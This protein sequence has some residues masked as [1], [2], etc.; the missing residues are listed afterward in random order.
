VPDLAAEACFGDQFEDGLAVLGHYFQP[1]QAVH[2]GEV[3]ATEA[4]PRQK[5]IDA[6]TQRLVGERVHRLGQGL[7]APGGGLGAEG[8][9]RRVKVVQVQDY[10]TLAALVR[11]KKAPGLTLFG[12]ASGLNAY[13]AFFK[14]QILAVIG[15]GDS[16]VEVNGV[17]SKVVLQSPFRISAQVPPD[18]EPGVYPVRVRSPYGTAEQTVEVL[19]K[20]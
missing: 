1:G 8:V 7:R 13:A 10:G 11:S 17:A 3:N 12:Q 19:R 20:L 6:I 14:N 4:E 2:H 5:D 16:A 9:A 15:G 18:L